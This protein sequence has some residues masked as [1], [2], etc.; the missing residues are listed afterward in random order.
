[1][2]WGKIQTDKEKKKIERERVRYRE[3][4][5]ERQGKVKESGESRK[6]KGEERDR[7]RERR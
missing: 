6:E 2:K 3:T 5:K 4:W 1:M 7:W